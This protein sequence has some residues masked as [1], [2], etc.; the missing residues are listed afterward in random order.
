MLPE[1]AISFQLGQLGQQAS[2]NLIWL[3]LAAILPIVLIWLAWVWL[4]KYVQGG[5]RWLDDLLPGDF[6]ALHRPTSIAI[7]VVVSIAILVPAVIAILWGF[8]VNVDAVL[9]ASSE[10]GQGVGRWAVDKGVKI[11]LVVFLAFLAQRLASRAIPRM[12]DGY[13]R[14]RAEGE[15]DAEID[16]RSKTLS[17]VLARAFSLVIFLGVIF[18]ALAQLGLNLAPLLAAAG[19]VGIAVG[20]G[21]QSLIRDLFAGLFIILENQYRIGDVVEI[22]GVAGLVEDI[23]LRRTV[24]RDLDYKQHFIPNGEIRVATNL[25]KGKSRVNLN[26]GVAYKED[27]DRVI[28][29]LNEVGQELSKDPYFGPLILDSIKV[30]RVDNFADSAIEIKVLGETL[31]I[32]QWDVAGEYRRRVKKAFDKC[33]IEI[34]FPHRTL[35]W[36]AGEP[37]LLLMQRTRGED[38]QKPQLGKEPQPSS[39]VTS[40]GTPLSPLDRTRH[41]E[42]SSDVNDPG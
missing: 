36:G 33:G 10:F 24:L 28:Q 4:P 3:I 38:G 2:E 11:L 20:F 22:A 37:N 12:I 7:E 19:V 14:S 39:G 35:Y 18:M 40:V 25:T 16:K 26:I 5:L 41:S 31:P 21:A 29:V 17:G 8:G 30:L 34:P 9:Q 1:L 15:P 42:T 27:L 13:I 23:N 6:S 32:R